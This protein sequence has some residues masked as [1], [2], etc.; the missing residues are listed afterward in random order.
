MKFKFGFPSEPDS[1][2][3][4]ARRLALPMK[5]TYIVATA[6]GLFIMLPLFYG[7]WR[8]RWSNDVIFG[9]FKADTI[10]PLLSAMLVTVIAHEFC[11]LVM[12]PFCGLTDKSYVGLDK[13]TGL[14][15]AQYLGVVSKMHFTAIG[16]APLVIG[17]II[18]LWLASMMPEWASWLAFASIFNAVGAGGDVYILAVAWR[19]VPA[20]MSLQGHRFGKKPHRTWRSAIKNESE[21]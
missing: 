15:Y 13:K 6:I 3:D 1:M 17:T 19:E 21:R 20:Q 14:A 5:K 7:M 10:L 12:H 16:V 8:M 18:S 9:V 2:L 11:H 4:G